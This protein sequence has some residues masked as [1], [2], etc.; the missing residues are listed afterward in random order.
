M[1]TS[2]AINIP[3]ADTS[4]VEI[5]PDEIPVKDLDY[6]DLIDVLR[7]FYAPLK[8]WRECAVSKSV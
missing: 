5:F 8:L 1:T 4:F 2:A 3:I 7:S 6:N